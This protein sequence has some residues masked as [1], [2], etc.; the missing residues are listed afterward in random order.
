MI[1]I[2]IFHDFEIFALELIENLHRRKD[3]FKIAFFYQW[4]A[5][6]RCV[7]IDTRSKRVTN[8]EFIYPEVMKAHEIQVQVLQVWHMSDS[9]DSVKLSVLLLDFDQKT[10]TL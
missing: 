5:L 6:F 9:R 4:F 7:T 1:F 2:R 8:Y 3:E 10:L